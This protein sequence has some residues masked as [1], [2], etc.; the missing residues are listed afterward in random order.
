M[1]YAL[2]YGLKKEKIQIALLKFIQWDFEFF[3]GRN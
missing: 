3:K 2:G 1:K